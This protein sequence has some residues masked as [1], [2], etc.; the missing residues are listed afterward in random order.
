MPASPLPK[1]HVPRVPHA[2]VAMSTA[3]NT[4]IINPSGLPAPLLLVV[5]GGG[6][7]ALL[8][9]YMLCCRSSRPT[10]RPLRAIEI[11]QWR[12]PFDDDEEEAFS[13]RGHGIKPPPSSVSKAL[14]ADQPNRTANGSPEGELGSAVFGA[15]DEPASF[16]AARRGTLIDGI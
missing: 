13:V 15:L 11:A 5:A 2:S 8:I 14:R 10:G 4:A 9:L 3:A 6:C 12:E 16:G 1:A 7:L